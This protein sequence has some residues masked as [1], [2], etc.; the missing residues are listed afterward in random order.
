EYAQ[1]R[2]VAREFAL[3]GWAVITGGGPGVMEAANRG[4]QENGGLSVGFG[5][6]LPHEQAINAYCD[7]AYTF[8]HFYARKV[9]FVKP[10]DGFVV[11][12]GGIGTLDELFE[13]YVLIQ[14]EKVEMFP[15]VL[16]GSG[17]WAGIIAWLSE[18]AL[19]AGM[20]SASDLDI[21]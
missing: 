18:T 6:E 5:I 20:I 4:A 15:L 17:Y 14:T 10:A 9:C 16:F 7:L 2:A 11:M 21:F 12:P 13:A 19:R 1:A 8:E 3:H